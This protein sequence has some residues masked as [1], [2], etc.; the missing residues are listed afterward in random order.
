MQLHPFYATVTRPVYHDGH[1]HLFLI[2]D[3]PQCKG[4]GEVEFSSI[5]PSEKDGSETCTC[6][7]GSGQEYEQT[8]DDELNGI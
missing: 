8:C 6:C 5:K 4:V 2:V 1:G 7:G 3:C